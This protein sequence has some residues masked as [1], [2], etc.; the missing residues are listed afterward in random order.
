M[1]LG[2]L[3]RATG[4]ALLLGAAMAAC[5]GGSPTSPSSSPGSG[6]GSSTTRIT[7]TSSGVSPTEITVSPGTRV[8]FVNNDTRSHNMSSDQHPEHSDCPEI[9]QAG[10]LQPGQSRETGNLTAVRTCGFHD[11][12]N[13]SNNSLRGRIVIR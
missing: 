4:V 2:R 5:G 13:P 1:T 6:G 7:I 11:H 8:T 3:L 10:M 9:N 12:D